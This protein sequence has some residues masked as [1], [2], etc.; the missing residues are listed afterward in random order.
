MGWYCGRWERTR[1]VPT[2]TGIRC[3]WWCGFM[4]SVEAGAKTDTPTT[5]GVY[6]WADSAGVAGWCVETPR[7]RSAGGGVGAG[8]SIGAGGIRT[9]SIHSKTDG[10][11]WRCSP[12]GFEN[13][14][15]DASCRIGANSST[16]GV[17]SGSGDSVWLDSF[18][19]GT[20][21][22]WNGTV[23]QVHIPE[24]RFSVHN[25]FNTAGTFVQRLRGLEIDFPRANLRKWD[26]SLPHNQHGA[27][28]CRIGLL[29]ELRNTHGN[30]IPG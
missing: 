22:V 10:P 15:T 30:A 16:A 7:P 28:V 5:R 2:S 26:S 9:G 3:R 27:D 24:T 12:I 14:G 18:S 4:P 20:E 25:Q 29:G 6:S 17:L 8:V 23:W 1:S 19:W 11:L 21:F 13:S